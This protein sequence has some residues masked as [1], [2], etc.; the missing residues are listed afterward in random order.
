M[1]QMLEKSK[2]YHDIVKNPSN[3]NRNFELFFIT[4]K[5]SYEDVVLQALNTQT[6]YLTPLNVTIV[7]IENLNHLINTSRE[8]VIQSTVRLVHDVQ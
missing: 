5:S 3:Y 8:N 7:L 1:N 6:T 2:R 4:E